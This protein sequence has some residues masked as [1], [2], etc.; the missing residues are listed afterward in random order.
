MSFRE[1]H[2]TMSYILISNLM[3]LCG[4]TS[5]CNYEKNVKYVMQISY[6]KAHE[7]DHFKFQILPATIL[8]L[9][10]KH[11]FAAKVLA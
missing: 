7:T 5:C 11:F 10:A 3:H 2:K 6:V 8:M 9:F 1:P 4:N